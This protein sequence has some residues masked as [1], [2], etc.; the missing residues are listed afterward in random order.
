M[1]VTCLIPFYNERDR[2]AHVLNVIT[3]VPQ[4]SQV[5]CVDDGST[6][7]TSAYI[8]ANWPAVEV[9]E[10]PCNQGKAAAIQQGVKLAKYELVLM[11]DADLQELQVHEIENAIQAFT[12]Q[13]TVDMLILRR[14]NSPWFV[15]WYRSDILLSGERLLWK[16][17][18]EKALAQAAKRYQLEVAINRYMLRHK[19][20][21][22]WVP[23]SAVNTYKV[24]KL[25]VLDGS[26]KEFRMYVEIVSFVGFS[27]MMRQL[28]SF[29]KRL[30]YEHEHQAKYKS[31]Y[32][33]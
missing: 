2:I 31:T 23:W 8:K 17:D 18:L 29:R 7:G 30:H 16:T 6:D 22:R 1:S 5:V 15:R 27:H 13:R 10:L 4:I 14:I 12:E 25:G 32:L 26:K 19:K 33:N 11:M 21:V 28:T 20:V 9:L 24:D 3:M